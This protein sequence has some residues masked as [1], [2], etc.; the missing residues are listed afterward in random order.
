MKSLAPD[1]AHS[2]ATGHRTVADLFRQLAEHDLYA[3]RS[4]SLVP[5]ENILS[6]V[7]KLAYQSDAIGRY[8][9]NE[10]EVFGRWS[11]QGGS[12]AG[13]IQRSILLPRLREMGQARHVNVHAISGL[14]GMLIAQAA[15]GGEPGSTIFSVPPRMGG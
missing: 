13:E 12:I 5:S 9:F 10:Y 14:T 11:F 2:I 15:F 8:F 7:A 1:L 4:F 3:R 6:P